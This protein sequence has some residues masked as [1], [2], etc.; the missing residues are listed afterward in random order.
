M[1]RDL[2][3]QRAPALSVLLGAAIAAGAAWWLLE[4]AEMWGM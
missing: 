3:D 2:T 4:W 1:R